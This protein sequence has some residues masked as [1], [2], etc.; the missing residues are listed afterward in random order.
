[1]EA[2]AIYPGSCGEIIQGHI[3]GRD[4]LMS[5]P[6]NMFTK[7]RVVECKKPEKRFAYKKSSA[8][9]ENMLKRWGLGHLNNR[10]DID[11]E[12]S[13]PQSKGFASSTADLC[14]V[15][16]CLLKLFK[17][18]YDIKEAIEE[19]VKI[20]PT[21]STIFREMTL[22]DY[23]KGRYYEPVGDYIKFYIL[24]FEGG[25]MV[26]T[27]AYNKSDLPPL[28]DLSDILNLVKDG[29]KSA[30]ISK[31]AAAST[32]SIKRN[33][34]RMPYDMYDH[35]LHLSNITG[36]LGIIG[37]HSGDVLG[38]IYDDKEKFLHAA[39][40]KYAISGYKLHMIETLRRDEY[41]R[42]YD[43]GAVQREREDDGDNRDN[44]GPFKHGA[45]CLRF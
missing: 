35:V 28:S 40:Y 5:C 25:R 7:V 13:I 9:L 19:F 20:E 38:I 37:G 12:S 43:Y 29:I 18:K 4:L 23:K 42:D 22:F 31:I 44:K 10:F 21:D 2:G 17:R 3:Y 27:I 1:M 14:G 8:L 34:K 24:A 26:D 45:G 30:D 6:V 11:I 15:Y 16:L 39:G 33:L 41:E 32:V 36:G